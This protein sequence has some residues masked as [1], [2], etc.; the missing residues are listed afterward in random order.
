MITGILLTIA[1]EGNTAGR[2]YV[3]KVSQIGAKPTDVGIRRV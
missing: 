1:E 2:Q 3:R